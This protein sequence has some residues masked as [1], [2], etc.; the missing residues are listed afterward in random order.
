MTWVLSLTTVASLWLA[1]NKWRWCW[2]FS[3]ANQ[4]LWVIWNVTSEN[5]G[6]MPMSLI[7]MA[8][9]IRNHRI[10]NRKDQNE[11]SL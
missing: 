9:A 5:W 10:W 11:K 6:F 1:G 3:A 4:V 7:F 8:V 2:L